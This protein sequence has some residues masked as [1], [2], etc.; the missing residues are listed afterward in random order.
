MLFSAFRFGKTYGDDTPRHPLK[1][2]FVVL[3]FVILGIIAVTALAI[4]FGLVVQWLW[5][6]LMP[7]IFSLPEVTYWQAVGLVVLG[8]IFFGNHNHSTKVNRGSRHDNH[9]DEK[10]VHINENGHEHHYDSFR[11]FWNDYGRDAF[12]KWLNRNEPKSEPENT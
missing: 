3:G 11:E 4:I 8:H 7:V 12:D 10:H 5:N 9:S 2:V 6:A 1:K